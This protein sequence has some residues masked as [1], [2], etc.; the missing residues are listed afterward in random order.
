MKAMSFYHTSSIAHRDLKPENILV[1]LDHPECRTKVIDFG[2]AAQ[3][4]K[5]ME[6][7]CG[8]PA[9]MSPEICAKQK[10][11]GSATDMWASGILLYTILF[12]VQPFKATNEKELFRKIVKG[13]FVM[14]VITCK[15]SSSEEKTLSFDKFPSI[16]HVEL[17]RDMLKDI[18][19]PA[20]NDRLTAGQVL[21][22][23]KTWFDSYN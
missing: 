3:S 11:L 8:T 23:Y 16:K 4:S 22:K 10:Y 12:G 1:D 17:I 9:Y 5:K 6:I 18:L 7:F 15:T 13:N 20:E 2:F 19:N 14:P 21:E